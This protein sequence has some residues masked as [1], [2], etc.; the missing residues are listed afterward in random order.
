[1]FFNCGRE[2]D[3]YVVSGEAIAEA[4]SQWR[5]RDRKAAGRLFGSLKV[6]KELCGLCARGEFKGLGG[7]ES[8]AMRTWLS[9]SAIRRREIGY[10]LRICWL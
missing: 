8:A 2:N 9:S 4:V 5:G 10:R 1:M 7:S 3:L 6:W